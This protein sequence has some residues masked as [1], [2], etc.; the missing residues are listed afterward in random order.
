M[1]DS[2]Q[3]NFDFVRTAAALAV[4]DFVRTAAALAVLV[5]HQFALTGRPEPSLFSAHSLGGIGVLVFFAIS[6]YLVSQSWERDPNIWRFALR[7]MLRIWPALA[8]VTLL[9]AFVLGPLVSTLPATEYFGSGET[10]AYLKAMKFTVR[11][12]LPG[13]FEGNPYPNAVNGSLW[14]IRIEVDWYLTLLVVGVV[15]LLR[16]R[17]LVLAATIVLA[18]V[19]F[20]TNVFVD[21]GH[22]NFWWEFGLFFCAGA[23]LNSFQNVWKVQPFRV[24]AALCAMG[25][26][27]FALG[28]PDAALFVVLPVFV[29]CFGTASFPLLRRF[30]RFGDLSYGIYVYAFPTQQTVTW[31][32]DNKLPFAAG[33]VLTT[34]CTTLLAL[35]SWHWVEKPALDLKPKVRRSPALIAM[36]A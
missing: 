8:V 26:V 7:R 1:D 23:C 34:L 4:F 13:V 28:Y 35:M 29:I 24:L 36:P 16:Q 15:G 10:W 14:T 27:V 17:F 25:A 20:G 11:Y 31:L 32:T 19:F 5:S 6:G 18:F 30:G 21:P 3:N 2:R 9:C 12:Q 22:R 33:L